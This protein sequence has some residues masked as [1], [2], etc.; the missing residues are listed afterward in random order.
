MLLSKKKIN[1]ARYYVRNLDELKGMKKYALI[2]LLKEYGIDIDPNSC[3]D[4][5]M[6]NKI[7]LITFLG[8]LGKE[9]KKK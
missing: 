8:I 4:K 7:A 2:S 3:I 6:M 5:G 1:Q 9:E